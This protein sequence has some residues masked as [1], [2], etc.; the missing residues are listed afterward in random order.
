ML[1]RFTLAAR[2]QIGPRFADSKKENVK[3]KRW[4]KQKMISFDFLHQLF[5]S[6]FSAP[7]EH[8]SPHKQASEQS[9]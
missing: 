6:S 2:S 1:L 5:A 8:R 9:V 7:R 3:E 4:C